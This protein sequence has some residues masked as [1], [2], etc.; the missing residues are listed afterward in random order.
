MTKFKIIFS[1]LLATAT[2]SYSQSPIL[3]FEESINK[4]FVDSIEYEQIDILIKNSTIETYLLWID[5]KNQDSKNVQD[6]INRYFYTRKG[7]FTLSNL[8]YEELSN[9]LPTQLY[10]TFYKILNPN[11]QFVISLLTKSTVENLNDFI[12]SFK[13][14]IVIINSK[15]SKRLPPIKDLEKYNFKGKSIILSEDMIKNN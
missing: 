12:N 1:I 11:D 4:Y 6:Q 3:Q 14:Q 7:D 13:K 15:V 9:E 8:L 2:T 10:L 5:N